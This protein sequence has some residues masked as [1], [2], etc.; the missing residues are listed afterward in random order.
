M[1]TRFIGSTRAIEGGQAVTSYQDFRAHV[2]G[3]DWNHLASQI[4]LEPQVGGNSTVQSALSSIY[5][6]I[7]AS[8]TGFISIG[9]A[10]TNSV[11]N[12]NLGSTDYPDWASLWTAA[13]SDPRI[14]S[15]GTILMMTGTYDADST[16]DLPDGYSLTIIGEGGSIINCQAN[17]APFK[18]GTSS[19][20]NINGNSGS[21]D[22]SGI[23][24]SGREQIQFQ[25]LIFTDNYDGSASSGAPVLTTA[26]FLQ[27]KR[28]GS[29]SCYNVS[30]IGRLADGVVLNR[31]KSYAAVASTTG[32]ATGTFIEFEK[33]YFDGL[34]K[35]VHNTTQLGKLDSL[36]IQNSKFRWF[37]K[38]AGSYDATD[39]SAVYTSNCN[40]TIQNNYL[41]AG[42][43]HTDTLVT[44][45]TASNVD[46]ELSS[47]ITGNKG[48]LNTTNKAYLV[49]NITSTAFRM[50]ISGNS[51]DNQMQS[52]FLVV[53][54]G[55]TYDTSAVGD[56][57]GANAINT[58]INTYGSQNQLDAT[59][60]V[61]P[62]TYTVTL[63]ATAAQNFSKLKFVGNKLGYKY[64]IFQLDI[65]SSSTSQLGN[66]YF[67]MGN[68]LEGI[69]FTSINSSQ[70]VLVAFNPTTNTTQNTAQNI[71]VKDCVFY[72]TSL[73]T[74][75]LGAGAI[76]DQLSH[77]TQAQVLIEGCYFNQ[78]GLF[79][80]T[81][82]FSST[83]PNQVVV[84][85][86]QFSGEGYWIHIEKTSGDV[87]VPF[88]KVVL[89]NVVT[90][91]SGATLTV[92]NPLG[93]ISVIDITCYDLLISNCK[94]VTNNDME[95]FP[96]YDATVDDNPG[97]FITLTCGNVVVQNS[98][99]N[100]P[101]QTFEDGADNFLVPAMQIVPTY[102]VRL[103]GNNFVSGALPLQI[104]GT[105]ASGLAQNAIYIAGNSFT[106]SDNGSISQCMLD[107]DIKHEEGQQTAFICNNTFVS[108]SEGG[109]F[110]VR[111]TQITSTAYFGSGIVQ[112]Y[113][114]GLNV[115][116]QGNHV[117]G[118]LHPITG[119]TDYA[120]VVLNNWDGAGDSI[121]GPRAQVYGNNILV[122][123]GN[124]NTATS[125]QTASCL[126]CRSYVESIYHNN[127]MY[128]NGTPDLSFAGCLVVDGR[129]SG[130]GMVQGNNF[131]RTN[132]DG[133]AT[134][135]S[136]GYI[137]IASTTGHRGFIVG[138]SFNSTTING[139]STSL[140]EDNTVAASSNWWSDQNRNQVKTLLLRGN[141]GEFGYRD[142]VVGTDESIVLNMGAPAASYLSYVLLK[143]F[144]SSADNVEFIYQDT[145]QI[146]TFRWQIDLSGIIPYGAYVT[147]V[148]VACDVSANAA[149][150][151]AVSTARL[152]AIA[153]GSV[154]TSASS[155]SLTTAGA[156]LAISGAAANTLPSLGSNSLALEL[157]WSFLSTATSIF[158]CGPITIT[159]RF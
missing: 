140:I 43:T 33:C 10:N 65:L 15:G 116:F 75:P 133:T 8:G 23:L 93:G 118:E 84:R 108:K 148:S 27:I 69:Y 51:F 130:T 124:V 80:A 20:P 117:S 105:L 28:G 146:L 150:G 55:G 99:V 101:N 100:G 86:C 152:A 106:T 76:V 14:S 126:Y 141:Q 145:N 68:Y 56:I 95:N 9:L 44:I 90:N 132:P 26:P 79:D 46:T 110:H 85:N 64:P 40:L 135:L 155:A 52:W 35:I 38:E 78:S 4:N 98:S 127:F 71:Y 156:T 67:V 113:C 88:S 114:K 142:A 144:N 25:D 111:H 57:N 120:G 2:S 1:V 147:D 29:L 91:N 153:S 7:S 70:S 96:L 123:N 97:S 34:K 31:S 66:K 154:V 24:G 149:G 5:S 22:Q 89:E 36:I 129:S 30:F 94:F 6:Q 48:Y 32:N 119:I 18:I 39:D 47:A 103:I 60:I 137:Q 49:N 151:G 125:T 54:G 82:S 131:N 128:L 58:V 19:A 74:L 109:A 73:E 45:D 42:G 81:V 143:Q 63:S 122:V 21:G 13:L 157:R 87:D 134:S 16:V 61:N 12:Y 121:L 136:R 139:S 11:G 102:G 138:N 72:N 107:L 50:S 112:L 159:Y 3:G 41:V 158:N 37:G 53:G 77:A 92:L 115:V 62:G 104:T 83:L 17:S 59:I